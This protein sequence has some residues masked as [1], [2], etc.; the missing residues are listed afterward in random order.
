MNTSNTLERTAQS[1]VFAVGDHA[2]AHG[3]SDSYAG[4]IMAVSPNGKR[5]SFSRGNAK[6]LNGMNS[7]EADALQC[8]VG[9][10]CG[11]V[12]GSQ[13]WEI[14]PDTVNGTCETFSL[15]SNGK[16]VREGESAKGGMRLTAG[17]SHHYDYN[18]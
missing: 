4:Y 18:F 12:S 3:Y 14:T 13:R 8:A 2:T 5:V 15:R 17:H 1:V 16:W 10:F 7:Q 9:G 6:L 11:H